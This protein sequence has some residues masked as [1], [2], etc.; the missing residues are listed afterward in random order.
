MVRGFL[1]PL[2]TIQTQPAASIS[3][4]ARQLKSAQRQQA[5]AEGAVGP[6]AHPP[7][8][9]T[10]E[11]PERLQAA[12]ALPPQRLNSPRAPIR[13][14][15][16]FPSGDRRQ[17]RF[18]KDWRP[19][20]SPGHAHNPSAGLHRTAAGR[21]KSPTSVEAPDSL[22]VY[23]P[24]PRPPAKAPTVGVSG[25]PPA[26]AQTQSQSVSHLQR[27]K[28][29]AEMQQL[30]MHQLQQRY[31][32]DSC[33][34]SSIL[35]DPHLGHLFHGRSGVDL[36]DKWRTLIKTRP[37]LAAYT[38]NRKNHRKYRPFSAT[39]ERALLEGV[40]KYNGQRNVWS[41]IL[42][43]KEL[44]PQFNDRSNVQLKDK[45]RT[46]RR[47][48][49]TSSLLVSGGAGAGVGAAKVPVN[50]FRSAEWN[51]TSMKVGELASSSVEDLLLQEAGAN[52]AAVSAPASDMSSTGADQNTRTI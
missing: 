42:I 5:P 22:S 2:F 45:F 36:K 20:R 12:A 37:E 31:A 7:R 48:G 4:R 18:K 30:Q 13:P 23:N 38:E 33:P 50:K 8:A 34:W 15:F 51:F 16:E 10:P 27:L 39:E 21:G 19:P 26:T 49:A 24:M 41:L 43:D 14:H 29:E 25:P 28:E 35:R 1:I 9:P 6:A 17:L 11:R 46:M 40:K 32:D 52:P 47:A 44:G 3:K